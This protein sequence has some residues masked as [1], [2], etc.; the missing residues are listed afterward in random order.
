MENGPITE[1]LEQPEP[2]IDEKAKEH[3]YRATHT[4]PIAETLE[5]PEPLIGEKAKEYLYQ[6]IHTYPE[7]TLETHIKNLQRSIRKRDFKEMNLPSL[8]FCIRI[9]RDLLNI[10]SNRRILYRDQMKR[11]GEP[12]TTLHFAVSNVRDKN[13]SLKSY[14]DLI[15]CERQA[16]LQERIRS[17]QAECR[18]IEKK[19]PQEY[20][21]NPALFKNFK[22]HFIELEKLKHPQTPEQATRNADELENIFLQASYI[23]EK[24]THPKKNKSKSHNLPHRTGRKK[25]PHSKC[26]GKTQTP[27]TKPYKSFIMGTNSDSDSGSES[28]DSD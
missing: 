1:T 6:A 25:I 7:K 28:S 22:N 19:V 8:R 23:K 4:E 2:L 11:I 13:D 5:Q 27:K 17:I 20:I 16:Q 14:L 12:F 24:H 18:D 15:F 9:L 21:E 10:I 26:N 3:L